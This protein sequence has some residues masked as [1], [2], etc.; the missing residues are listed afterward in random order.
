M[1]RT[2]LAIAVALGMTGIAAAQP[3]IMT[4]PRGD[5]I[6]CRTD[7]GAAGLMYALNQRIPDIVELR[8]GKFSPTNPAYDLFSGAWSPGGG[9][10]R[11]DLVVVGV[12]NPPGTLG[13]DDKFPAYNPF[14]YG[15]NPILGWIE[16]DVDD[17][18]NTGSELITPQ[19]RYL[20]NAA[21]LGGLP[22]GS[23]LIDHFAQDYHAFDQNIETSPCVE[24]SGEEFH[25]ALLGEHIESVTVRVEKPGGNPAIFEAGE[26]WRLHGT[27]WHRAHGFEEFAFQCLGKDGR[28][29][30]DVEMR[31]AHDTSTNL[32]TIT[33][34]YPLTNAASASMYGPNFPAE[35]DDG[36]PGDQNSVAEGLLDLNY[37]ATYATY[38]DR[39]RPDFAPLAEW[40]F[41]DV[42]QQLNPAN[43]RVDAIVGTAYANAQPDGSL[44]IWTD[45]I[46]SGRRGDFDGNGVIDAGDVALLL[47]YLANHDGEPNYDDDGNCGN[48]RIV[49]HDFAEN[50]SLFDTNADGVIEV[51]DAVI[52]GDMDINMTVNAADVDDFVQALVAPALY[53]SNHGGRH[54]AVRGDLNGDGNL[55]GL[56]VGFFVQ[57]VLNCP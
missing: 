17:N 47:A 12:I 54:P 23:P 25:L 21:R 48:N 22:T 35:P 43:W 1:R 4:D 57:L 14:R 33:L 3:A 51:S 32:T 50:F 29:M 41:V 11:F 53:A 44:F 6:I 19:L 24:R 55:D 8:L 26:D 42:S 20:G 37:S 46:P 34:V 56:D 49:I 5:A 27:L 2:V 13:Y 36:C 40:E 30:P 45:A 52:L 7:R 10:V 28:Y 16:F 9:F 18:I 31:F 39:L 38:E 15:P